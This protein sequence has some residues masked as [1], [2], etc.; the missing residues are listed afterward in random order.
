[1]DINIDLMMGDCIIS[2]SNISAVPSEFSCFFML[3]IR[4]L[5]NATFQQKFSH[6]RYTIGRLLNLFWDLHHFEL[7]NVNIKCQYFEWSCL[8]L[9]QELTE[10]YVWYYVVLLDVASWKIGQ[11][12][13][14]EAEEGQV[15]NISSTLTIW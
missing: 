8:H 9:I 10:I 1:M 7:G 3:H 12:V 2:H 14:K 6:E 5:M 4:D 11:E 15:R 13:A